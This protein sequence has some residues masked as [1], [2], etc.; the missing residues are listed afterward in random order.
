MGWFQPATPANFIG[1]SRLAK[2]DFCFLNGLRFAH[3]TKVF[4]FPDT[5]SDSSCIVRPRGTDISQ[6]DPTP[7]KL[8]RVYS[9]ITPRSLPGWDTIAELLPIRSSHIVHVTRATNRGILG[10]ITC[11]NYEIPCF[12]GAEEFPDLELSTL[13]GTSIAVSVVAHH[14]E[15]RRIEFEPLSR[16]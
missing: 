6:R 9:S 4:H 16:T 12:V 2:I 15:E 1:L 14:P 13:M 10:C 7:I 5:K 11:G 3:P 8:T